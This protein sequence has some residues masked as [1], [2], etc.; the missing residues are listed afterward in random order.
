MPRP[1]RPR[2]ASPLV[3]R[4]PRQ[5]RSQ[6]VLDRLVAAALDLL[7]ER[8]WETIAIADIAS[9]AGVSVGVMYT[10]FPTKD[11]LLVHLAGALA[12]EARATV[13]EAFAE[14]AVAGMAL[15]ELAELYFS[16]A[17]RTFVKHRRL[18]RAVTLMVRTTEHAELR[19]IV[20]QFN[21]AVHERLAQTV[22]RHRKQIRHDDAEGAVNF[23]ILAASA[24]LR[25]ILLYEEPVSQLA[26]GHARAGHEAAR[27]F[28]S[29]L[30]CAPSR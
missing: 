29:Y 14:D 26:R 3:V 19:P 25:E 5:A 9:R 13:A 17:A 12:E 18:F 11:H 22:L 27:I 4:E 1:P 28:T 6:E 10:R 23:A 16:I 24:T 15:A 20:S 2:A 30:T 21:Q 7:D 8:D